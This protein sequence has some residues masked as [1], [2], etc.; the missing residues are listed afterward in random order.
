M[1]MISAKFGVRL[2]GLK[3][4]RDGRRQSIQLKQAAALIAT[5]LS[6]FIFKRFTMFSKGGGDWP[7]IAE[8]TARRKGNRRILYETGDFQAGL[9]MG[10]NQR[11]SW[12]G[13]WLN[14]TYSMKAR[15]KHKPSKLPIQRLLEIHQLGLGRVPKRPVIV[16]P[17]NDVKRKIEQRLA[18]AIRAKNR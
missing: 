11:I 2:A 3:S 8:S 15:R 6:G 17:G 9:K 18:K 14:L 5:D 12:N 16:P 4:L 10:L 1:A 13:P 7:P